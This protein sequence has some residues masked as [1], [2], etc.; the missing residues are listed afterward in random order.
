VSE[1]EIFL[2]V[3]TD[4]TE[5]VGNAKIPLYRSKWDIQR[6]GKER[7]DASYTFAEK[8]FIGIRH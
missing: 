3:K 1:I 7:N 2:R 6:E 4:V 5:L 8:H